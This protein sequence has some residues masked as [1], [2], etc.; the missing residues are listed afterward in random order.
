MSSAVAAEA[1]ETEAGA[2]RLVRICAN[3]KAGERV[4]VISDDSTRAVADEVTAQARKITR[5]VRHD[6]IE[7]EAM[8]GSEPPA[9]VAARMAD[10]DVIFGLTAMSMAH[11]T[12][13]RNAGERGARYLS[14]PDYSLELLAS[15]ALRADFEDISVICN[16]IADV[17]DQSS[18]IRITTRAGTDLTLSTG[19]RL[20]NRCPGLVWRA[21]ELGSPPDAEVNIAPLEG[22]AHGTIVVDGSIPCREIG[23]LSAPVMLLV[24]DGRI[25]EINGSAPVLQTLEALFCKAGP[26]SRVLA[27]FGI[28]LNPQ[29][30]LCGVMLEDE[31]CAGTV[32]FGFGSNVTIGGLNK[33][34]FHLDFIV[35][36][37]TVF[38][39]NR[40]LLL[41]GELASGLDG[42]R[43]L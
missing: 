42:N 41:D 21:G 12:A 15:P 18:A 40:R 43:R 7:A 8:H 20:S 10:A 29:A 6:V 1:N 11:T 17:I 37:A 3:L 35:R 16:Q 25:A 14:L 32:H 30:R 9:F 39:D 28:G 23:L 4:Y 2:Q 13:R 31:G 38:C 24:L 36:D 34:G 27:E 33:V 19:S 5:E 26:K 22:T